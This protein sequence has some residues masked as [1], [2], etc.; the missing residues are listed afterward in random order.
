MSVYEFRFTSVLYDKYFANAF[1]LIYLKNYLMS[2]QY[3]KM[4]Q[5]T[6]EIILYSIRLSNSMHQIHLTLKLSRLSVVRLKCHSLLAFIGK[7]AFR[8]LDVNGNSSCCGVRLIKP[9]LNLGMASVLSVFLLPSFLPY[10]WS[11]AL[12]K[13]LIY[14]IL[15]QYQLSNTQALV[16]PMLSCLLPVSGLLIASVSALARLQNLSWLLLH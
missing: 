6:V 11:S 14:E 9:N 2:V 15:L 1:V 7:K 13:K 10:A 16:L 8:P 4:K 3:V 12:W 5:K